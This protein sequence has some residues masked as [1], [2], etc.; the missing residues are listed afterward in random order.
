MGR[1]K[2]PHRPT[3]R[4]SQQVEALTAAGIKPEVIAKTLEIS[5]E[6]LKKSYADELEYGIANAN[7]KVIRNL[8][9]IA[10]SNSRQAVP[11]IKLWLTNRAG[12]T[13]KSAHEITGADGKP[14][15]TATIALD[16]KTIEAIRRRYI[17]NSD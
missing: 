2:R 17:A 16:E 5:V 9:D 6:Q 1:P 10:T 4:S 15:E 14:I 3:G 7:A 11:A 12:W 8:Y 13:D